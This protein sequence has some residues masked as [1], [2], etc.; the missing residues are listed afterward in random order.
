MHINLH[1]IYCV[2]ASQMLTDAAFGLL[3]LATI[4][5]YVFFI[6]ENEPNDEQKQ[7]KKESKLLAFKSLYIVWLEVENSRRWWQQQQ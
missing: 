1:G 5:N 2:H 4:W 7:N 6:Q 3:Q